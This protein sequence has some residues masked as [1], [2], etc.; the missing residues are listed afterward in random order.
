MPILQ[1]LKIQVSYLRLSLYPY[2]A[3][4]IFDSMFA[5]L[6]YRHVKSFLQVE[7]NNMLVI[8]NS[9]WIELCVVYVLAEYI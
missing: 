2:L 7:D 6:G 3:E 5:N 1:P 4:F 8:L 9:I